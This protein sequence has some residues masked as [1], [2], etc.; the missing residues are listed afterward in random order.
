M[1]PYQK[2]F[3]LPKSPYFLSHSVGCLPKV[4]EQ[5]LHDNYL[6]PWKQQGGD[7]WPTWMGVIDHFHH[8]L[9]TLLDGKADD[10]CAQVNLSSA[11]TKILV[12]MSQNSDKK[13]VLMH[14]DAFPSMGFVVDALSSAGLQLQLIESQRSASDPEAWRE[15]I[16]NN[17]L[18]CLITHVHSNTGVLSP[19]QEIA[20]L[21]K[22]RGVFSIV[23]IAQSAGI[24]P[25]SLR[26]WQVD[27]VIG[28]CVK[29]LCGG[30]GAGYLWINADV[31]PSLKP[32]DVGW[33]S[34]Q[35][36][37]EFDIRH[38]DYAESAMRFMGGTP[39]IAPF[40]VAATSIGCMLE[41]GIDTIFQHNRK[42]L[43]YV[44]NSIDTA[45]IKP[46]NLD[47]NGGTLC[48]TLEKYNAIK[49]AKLLTEQ[50]CFF[51]QRANTLRLS[52][53]IYN[54]VQ[55]AAQIIDALNATSL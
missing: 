28:S 36:P 25:I 7:A 3:N 55:E 10:F 11:L 20:E 33:F 40:A 52:L 8:Q 21:C 12:A 49:T 48:L 29:W 32:S 15:A 9:A 30:P 35:D 44:L 51:D 16:C 22:E 54:D 23:D 14:A 27:C 39:S 31:L 34:H 5:A 38:F 50:H 13:I 17:T 19:V 43:S 1:N 53:H 46:V 45:N 26:Q 41:I 18:A 24:I 4:S 37:F 6:K 47:A 42:L 2:Q